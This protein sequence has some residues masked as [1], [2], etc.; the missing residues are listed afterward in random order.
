[1]AII[2]STVAFSCLAAMT[3]VTSRPTLTF[4]STNH[5]RV[6]ESTSIS[7]KLLKLQSEVT[8]EA[9]ERTHTEFIPSDDDSVN[10]HEKYADLLTTSYHDLLKLPT[11]FQVDLHTGL[12][13]R[14]DIQVL[15]QTLSVFTSEYRVAVAKIRLI[16][17]K[18][19]RKPC[20]PRC[21]PR[22]KMLC[23]LDSLRQK[24]QEFDQVVILMMQELRIPRPTTHVVRT[25][26]LPM[27][28]KLEFY[29][30]VVY[31]L[32][33]QTAHLHTAMDIIKRL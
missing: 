13:V 8:F 27:M 31:Q 2:Y 22:E 29:L 30:G 33:E 23:N 10:T 6:L 32:K 12:T 26:D 1:M 17:C 4:T 16:E 20:P 15:Y 7:L 5:Q 25:L 14:E 18:Q 11:L 28:A 24:L 21:H 19:L 9:F 3:V